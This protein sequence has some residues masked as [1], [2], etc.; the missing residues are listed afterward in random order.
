MTATSNVLM[1]GMTGG[2]MGPNMISADSVS[3]LTRKASWKLAFSK[4]TH[5]NA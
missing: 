4:E 2:Q 5:I 3:V 1:K